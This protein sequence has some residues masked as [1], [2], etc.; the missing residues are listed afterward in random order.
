MKRRSFLKSAGG[1]SAAIALLQA[2]GATEAAALESSGFTPCVN[3]ATT[4]QADFRNAL[5]AYSKAGF[6]AVEL[7]LDSVNRFLQKESVAVARRL[8]A[9]H[10]IVPVSSCCEGDLFFP[11]VPEREKR[12]DAFKRKLDLSAQLGA[13]RFVMYSAVFENVTQADYDAAIPGLHHVGE[14]GREF[15]ITVGI[16]FIR[17]AKFLG[18]LETTSRLLRKVRHPNLGVLLDTFHFY[19]GTSKLEDIENLN[20]GE[21]S[22]VHIDDVPAIPREL[23]EDGHRVFVG[24]GVIPLEKILGALAR[25]YRGPVSFEV[26]QYAAQ[27]PYPVA[28]KGFEGLS[29]LLAKL[30][31]A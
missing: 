15:Q 20:P 31:K 16:E 8:M 6:R 25:V 24:E 11:R 28:A 30:A 9:D 1:A 14:F 4:E 10:G 19:A 17:G 7:W 29:R 18:C 26:F 2:R 3:Q 5:D 21:I 23:L 12:L 27:D 22:F 13:P